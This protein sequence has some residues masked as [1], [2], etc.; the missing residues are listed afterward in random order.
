MT[1]RISYIV[2]NKFFWFFVFVVFFVLSLDFWAW[3][4][5]NPL[6]FGLPFWVFYLI[7]ITVLL[8]FVYY[9]FCLFFWRVDED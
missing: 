6:F 4:A 2:K 7:F 9:F 3:N 5:Y 8:T 1:G